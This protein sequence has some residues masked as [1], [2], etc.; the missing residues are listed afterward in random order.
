LG[1][2]VKRKISLRRTIL[3]GWAIKKTELNL[4]QKIWG[5]I[6]VK[7]QARGVPRAAAYVGNRAWNRG[8]K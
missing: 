6:A 8:R 4:R 1:S 7:V 5:W 3:E 2:G